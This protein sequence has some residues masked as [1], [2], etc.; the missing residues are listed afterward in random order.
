M[1]LAG[2]NILVTGASKGIG[3]GCALELAQAGAN[4]AI[5][6]YSDDAAAS[7]TAEQVRKLGRKALLLKG[8]VADQAYVEEMVAKN[9]LKYLPTVSRPKE[10][11]GWT[12]FAGRA[13]ALVEPGLIG[14]TEKALGLGPGELRPDRVAVLICGLN[15]TIANTIIALLSRGFIPENRKIRRALQLEDTAPSA[16]FWEQYDNTPVIDVKDEALMTDLRA[17]LRAAL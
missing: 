11:P 16:I 7:E 15:G 3:R 9:G 2:R 10:V 6:Y 13:E 12:G 1:K 17:R 8:D 14:E 5:N 4:V